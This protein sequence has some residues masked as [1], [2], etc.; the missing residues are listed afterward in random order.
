MAIQ[1]PASAVA[2][3]P[4]DGNA[5]DRWI[6]ALEEELIT[7][8][9]A[10]VVEQPWSAGVSGLAAADWL[11]AVLAAESASRLMSRIWISA[12]WLRGD[13]AAVAAKLQGVAPADEDELFMPGWNADGPLALP[14]DLPPAITPL[15]LGTYAVLSGWAAAGERHEER[16]VL[17]AVRSQLAALPP[18]VLAAGEAS[19]AG[20]LAFWRNTALVAQSSGIAL[21]R[22]ATLAEREWARLAPLEAAR[23]ALLEELEAA[24]LELVELKARIAIV[25]SEAEAA[26]ARETLDLH[27]EAAE[28]TRLSAERQVAIEHLRKDRAQKIAGRDKRIEK[29]SAQVASLQDQ[30]DAA[31]P[32]RNSGQTLAVRLRGLLR[33]PKSKIA[34]KQAERLALLQQS[35]LFDPIWYLA[36]NPDVKAEGVDPAAHYLESGGIEGRA[37]G[38]MF[39][40]RAYLAHYPDVRAAGANPLIHYLEH[41]RLEGREIRTLAQSKRIAGAAGRPSATSGETAGKGRQRIE[42][43]AANAA[44]RLASTDQPWTARALEFG[45]LTKPSADRQTQ[46]VSAP[47]AAAAQTWLASLMGH[48]TLEADD[49]DVA[50]AVRRW[51]CGNGIALAD[52]WFDAPGRARLRFSIGAGMDA[53][54]LR[55]SQPRHGTSEPAELFHAALHEGVVVAELASPSFLRP[56]LIEA[57]G[58]GDAVIDA[59]LVPF[60]S[61]WRGGIHFAEVVAGGDASGPLDTAV[62]LSRNLLANV[63][64]VRSGEASFALSRVVVDIDRANG[65]EMLLS[66][67]HACWLVHDLGVLLETAE[68]RVDDPGRAAI[69]TQ[70]AS[71]GAPAAPRSDAGTLRLAANAVPTLQA[72]FA[73]ASATPRSA[74]ASVM[75][76]D[77]NGALPDWRLRSADWTALPRDWQ[78]AHLPALPL[79]NGAALAGDLAIVTPRRTGEP[80]A[81]F[82][83]SGQMALPTSPAI[84]AKLAVLIDCPRSDSELAPLLVCVEALEFE[85]ECLLI[86]AD[87]ARAEIAGAVVPGMALRTIAPEGETALERLRAAAR[88]TDAPRVL[89]L[90]EDVVL[91]DRRVGAVLAAACDTGA[92]VVTSPLLTT[93][94]PAAKHGATYTASAGWIAARNGSGSIGAW[95][96]DVTPLDLPALFPNAAPDLRCAMLPRT[97]LI[98][99][100]AENEIAFGSEVRAKGGACLALACV[101]ASAAEVRAERY[102]GPLDGAAQDTLLIER[103]LR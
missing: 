75:Q 63:A 29:L 96:D 73:V 102:D 56:M 43:A 47:S 54:A 81:M 53:A 33:L 17:D 24:R 70:I 84:G 90:S 38:P 36:K 89:A 83:V 12:D 35:E 45:V 20:E 23:E 37:P 26:L 13:P 58:A 62:E 74:E 93:E 80:Q 15:L 69:A 44:A 34:A 10:V 46:E 101:S 27:R 66:R 28:Q 85:T 65:T 72:L 11:R 25:R 3:V 99:T 97:L 4:F 60:P 39:D 77:R 78:V 48:G 2:E 40:G 79:A 61:L 103:L 5:L 30:I 55:I 31:R 7:P 19:G 41:G 100:V 64:K 57:L 51:L 22:R 91:H 87:P 8:R 21:L 14:A 92:D 82:P 16:A 71:L 95:I 49:L 67:E 52:A 88:K 6:A 18:S 98:E 50:E 94:L 9:L 1:Q 42:Q 59:L 68:V 76:L 32:R 86:T